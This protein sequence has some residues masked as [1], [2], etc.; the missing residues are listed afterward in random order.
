VEVTFA[1]PVPVAEVHSLAEETGLQLEDF[2][3]AGCN[4]Q[5]VGRGV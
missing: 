1:H 2:L 5:G 3:V 4:S